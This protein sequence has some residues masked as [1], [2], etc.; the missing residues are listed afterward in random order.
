DVRAEEWTPSYAGGS[1]RV[2]FLLKKERII[3]EIKKT[4]PTLKAKHIGEQLIVDSQRYRAH[5]DCGRLLCFVYDPEGWVANPAGLE[6]DLNRRLWHI[7]GTGIAPAL[8]T[9]NL[10]S[11]DAQAPAMEAYRTFKRLWSPSTPLGAFEPLT[12]VLINDDQ[13]ERYERELMNALSNDEVLNIALTGGYGAGKSSVLKTF[14]RKHPEFETAYVSLATFSK[15][16]PTPL[17]VSDA[18]SESDAPAKQSQVAQD[19]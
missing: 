7:A 1:S 13:F 18:E 19:G 5:P 15:E 16:A 8:P 2:D 12:P 14:F 10:I 9:L 4:R 17:P 6:N 11:V 3:I